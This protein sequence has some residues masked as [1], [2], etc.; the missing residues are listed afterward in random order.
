MRRLRFFA[1]VLP[2]FLLCACLL[3]ACGKDGDALQN[4]NA[5]NAN[6]GAISACDTHTP[7]EWITVTAPGESREGLRKRLCT[8]C[9]EALESEVIPATGSIGL[10]YYAIGAEAFGVK[11]GDTPATE[12]IIPHSYAGKPVI[13]I[14]ERAFAGKNTL[15]S[16][17]LPDSLKAIATSAFDG[18]TALKSI[19]LPDTLVQIEAY[20]FR[21]CTALE[22]LTLP[23]SV[24]LLGH[25]A[26]SGCTE[27][28]KVT[29]TEGLLQIGN[30]AFA[31]CTSL[32]SVTL[33]EGLLHLGAS[34][35]SGCKA[36]TALSIPSTLQSVGGRVSYGC[37]RLSY[38]TYNGG[39]YLGNESNKFLLL[40]ELTDKDATAY[41][42]HSATVFVASMALDTG[43]LQSAVLPKTLRGLGVQFSL[44]TY[45]FAG[46]ATEWEGVSLFDKELY[47]SYV[48]AEK[49]YFYCDTTPTDTGNYWRYVMGAPKAW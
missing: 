38:H 19:T 7:G 18:C 49:L 29:F 2:L 21:G 12:I 48:S 23:G 37:E 27:L 6:G 32:V 34:A 36:L 44:P 1:T 3:A 16:V 42:V 8:V 41:T 22:A 35:F 4:N 46:N 11:A 5:D 25:G 9:G 14:G 40:E 24:T 30:A 10:V 20:A 33:P 17:T 31:D 43:A 28:T 39:S 45:Y 47:G 26:F 13:E 15:K